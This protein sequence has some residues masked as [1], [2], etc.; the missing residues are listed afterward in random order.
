M[1][2]CNAVVHRVPHSGPDPTSQLQ[3]ANASWLR[4]A[5]QQRPPQQRAGALDHPVQCRHVAAP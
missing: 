5:P 2:E 3:V 1:S 4:W